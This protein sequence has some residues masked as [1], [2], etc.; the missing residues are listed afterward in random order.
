MTIQNYQNKGKFYSATPLRNICRNS[1]SRADPL[2]EA[3]GRC[4]SITPAGNGLQEKQIPKG[5]EMWDKPSAAL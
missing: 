2:Q 3:L 1:P 5:K 4:S